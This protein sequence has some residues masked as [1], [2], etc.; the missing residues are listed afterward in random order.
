MIFGPSAP[1][2]PEI[3]TAPSPGKRGDD[4]NKA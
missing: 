1:V 4:F 3:G 2:H